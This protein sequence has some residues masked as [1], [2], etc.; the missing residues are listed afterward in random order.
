[1]SGAFTIMT[2]VFMP[3]DTIDSSGQS[4]NSAHKNRIIGAASAANDDRLGEAVLLRQ[5]AHPRSI[6]STGGW[7]AYDVWRRFIKEARE[8]RTQQD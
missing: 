1:M 5:E 3:P 6:E 4:M 2:T 8:R 7:D